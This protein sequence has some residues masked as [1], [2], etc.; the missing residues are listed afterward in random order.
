[1]ELTLSPEH[2]SGAEAKLIIFR[3]ERLEAVQ[4]GRKNQRFG[5]K[6]LYWISGLVQALNRPHKMAT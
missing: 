1:M 4:L 6:I 5:T 3:G 2:Y